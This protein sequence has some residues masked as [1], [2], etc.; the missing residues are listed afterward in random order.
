MHHCGR[1]EQC[2]QVPH[3]AAYASAAGEG[4]C[5]YSAARAARRQVC[6]LVGDEGDATP[7]TREVTVEKVSTKLHDNGYQRRGNEALFHL[8]PRAHSH[9]H[10]LAR[11]DDPNP[12]SCA[13]SPY[14]CHA[15]TT[16]AVARCRRW[17]SLLC[18]DFAPLH[19]RF[20]CSAEALCRRLCLKAL[21][22]ARQKAA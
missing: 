14:R 7:F 16:A 3:G 8:P 5:Y 6:A 9:S 4:H 22:R 13:P 2:E 21:Q 11:T 12:W 20:V 18:L 15:A 19:T 1:A 10:S 17:A